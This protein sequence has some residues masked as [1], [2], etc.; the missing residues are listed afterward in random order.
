V[1]MV[2]LLLL[3]LM[4]MKLEQ[5]VQLTGVVYV[6]DRVGNSFNQ[7][8]ILTGSLAV[9]ASDFFGISVATSA[10]GKTIIVG[11]YM[12]KLGSGILV[13]FMSLIKTSC[14]W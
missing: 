6:F 14:C 11:A 3:V 12:M 5:Q 2:K 9:N 1:P 7:V 10:D 13:L 4:L 8:G